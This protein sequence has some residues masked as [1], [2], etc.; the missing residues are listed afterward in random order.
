MPTIYLVDETAVA[1]R[2]AMDTR[3]EQWWLEPT[4]SHY[5]LNPLA[6]TI[7]GAS[8]WK[9]FVL[10]IAPEQKSSLNQLLKSSK[11]SA[12]VGTMED[13]KLWAHTGFIKWLS[14]GFHR[15]IRGWSWRSVSQIAAASIT[16]KVA[17]TQISMAQVARTG[18]SIAC[19]PP[20]IIDR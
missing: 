18:G 3:L 12:R 17:E 10:F 6:L 8:G 2:F 9:E 11:K 19:R 20:P 4:R 1:I 13:G 15:K 5:L 16:T 7:Y 14:E